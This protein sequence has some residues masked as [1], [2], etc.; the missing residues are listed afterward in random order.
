MILLNK[1]KCISCLACIAACPYG[2]IEIE[3]LFISI[4]DTKKCD[5]CKEKNCK[6]LCPTGA[7]IV[8]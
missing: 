6:I 8:S 2:I 1:N 5:I 3:G 7:I 4:K